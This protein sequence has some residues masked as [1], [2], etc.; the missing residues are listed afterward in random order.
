MQARRSCGEL[1]EPSRTAD[2]IKFFFGELDFESVEHA[3]NCSLK[4]EAAHHEDERPEPRTGQLL[5]RC[6]LKLLRVQIEH[7]F[8]LI[9]EIDALDRL[10]RKDC[11]P[12]FHP[13]LCDFGM[14]EF[15]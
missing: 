13:T 5:L 2:N 6:G 9:A 4:R 8:K 15:F 7:T 10:E 11:I 3:Q 14:D 12:T 1:V